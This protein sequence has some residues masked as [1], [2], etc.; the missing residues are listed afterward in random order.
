MKNTRTIK[1][2]VFMAVLALILM[3]IPANQAH[4]ASLT[5]AQQKKVTATEQKIKKKYKNVKFIVND[6]SSRFWDQIESRKG[7]KCYY[8]EK[9][10]GKVTNNKKDGTAAGYYI[11]YK[12]VNG[13][14][15]GSKVIS[16]F[17][18]SRTNNYCD[19]IIARYD[20]VIKR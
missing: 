2:M 3:V 8:V 19:D 17:V 6:G 1:T 9:V 12:R 18:Y 4:A 15:K 13:V 20:V 11:S 10:T 14:N 5:K 16:Y 7:K